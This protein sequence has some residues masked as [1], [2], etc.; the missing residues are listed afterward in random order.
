MSEISI[1]I[2]DDVVEARPDDQV[3]GSGDRRISRMDCDDSDS[4]ATLAWPVAADRL[5]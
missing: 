3:N 1:W 5:C 2:E 4:A